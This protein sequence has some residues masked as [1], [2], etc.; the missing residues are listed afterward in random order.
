MNAKYC[1]RCGTAYSGDDDGQPITVAY[2]SMPVM[3]K[4]NP[5]L[6]GS[7]PTAERDR[8]FSSARLRLDLC[9]NCCSSLAFWL[10]AGV[11][12]RDEQ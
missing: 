4:L 5:P 3:R 2:R 11:R 7:L 9:P 10:R 8:L 1:D 12:W 6:Y